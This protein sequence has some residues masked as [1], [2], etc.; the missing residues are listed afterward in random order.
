MP[1]RKRKRKAKGQGLRAKGGVGPEPNDDEI[2]YIPV[3]ELEVGDEILSL[4]EQTGKFEWQKVEK[5]MDKGVQAVIELVTEDGKKI[6]TTA[7]HPY[8]VRSAADRAGASGRSFGL[9][10]LDGDISEQNHNQHQGGGDLNISINSPE[11]EVSHDNFLSSIKARYRNN[12][13]N[14]MSYVNTK[15][16]LSPAIDQKLGAMRTTPYQPAERL[17]Q[18]PDRTLRNAFGLSFSKIS[19]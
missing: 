16:F 6:E 7:N 13:P 17:T 10:E 14:K 11:I 3:E 12:V 8:L 4:D 15:A 1:R 5:T 19:T 2:E 18:S 9:G